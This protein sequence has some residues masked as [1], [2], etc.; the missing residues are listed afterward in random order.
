M[1]THSRTPVWRIPWDRGAWRAPVHG[2]AKELNMTYRLNNNMCAP[3]SA[4]RP[5]ERSEHLIGR[6]H[7]FPKT[8]LCELT[9]PLLEDLNCVHLHSLPGGLLV[10]FI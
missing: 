9:S 8:C 10:L 7:L 1:V 4:W 6:S 5:R 3:T 2:V